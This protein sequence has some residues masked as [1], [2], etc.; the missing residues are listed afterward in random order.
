MAVGFVGGFAEPRYWDW[1]ILLAGLSGAVQL[2]WLGP[3]LTRRAQGGKRTW[4][5][6]LGA[7]ATAPFLGT[8]TYGLCGVVARFHAALW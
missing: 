6:L 2:G 1:S 7:T 4:P 8:L 5:L 3:L